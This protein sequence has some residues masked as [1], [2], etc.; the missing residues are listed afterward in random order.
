MGQGIMKSDDENYPYL[1]IFRSIRTHFPPS[2]MTT[3]IVFDIGL[4]TWEL[5]QVKMVCRSANNASQWLG[6][7]QSDCRLWQFPHHP[8][9][10]YPSHVRASAYR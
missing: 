8:L 1:Y 7:N 2:T 4:S 6:Q 10:K 3:V 9:L 5:E